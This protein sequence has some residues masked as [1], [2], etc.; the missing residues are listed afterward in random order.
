[1]TILEFIEKWRGDESGTWV[2]T[3]CA[4]FWARSY[5]MDAKQLRKMAT[6]YLALTIAKRT[7]CSHRRASRIVQFLDLPSVHGLV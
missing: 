1:M 5:N 4:L 2:E 3:P 6:D 7:P